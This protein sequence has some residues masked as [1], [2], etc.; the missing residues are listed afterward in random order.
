M[1]EVLGDWTTVIDVD[2][3]EAITTLAR[4]IRDGSVRPGKI[5]AAAAGELGP[6]RD[7]LRAVLKSAG[8]D[9][10]ASTIPTSSTPSVTA[11][12]LAGVG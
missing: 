5:A 12:A 11:R 2:P 4:H 10:I 6:T 9:A 3:S 8:E 7:R 1:L